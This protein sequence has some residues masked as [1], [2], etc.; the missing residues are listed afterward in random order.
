[1]PAYSDECCNQSVHPLTYCEK[2]IAKNGL[3]INET[4]K[5]LTFNVEEAKLNMIDLYKLIEQQKKAL[6]EQQKQ[7]EK[8]KE[9][10]SNTI[11]K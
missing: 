7:I 10:I 2:E 5:G 9:E 11:K 3:N 6:E 1:M 4:L 8:L